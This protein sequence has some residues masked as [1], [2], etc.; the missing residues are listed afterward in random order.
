VSLVV[1]LKT[2]PLATLVAVTF[3]LLIA[4]P[5]GSVTVPLILPV[6]VWAH[7]VSCDNRR[8]PATNETRDRKEKRKA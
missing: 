8:N 2:N 7:A 1:E 3:A 5:L 4:A 6:M